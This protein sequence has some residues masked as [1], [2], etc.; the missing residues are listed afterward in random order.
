MERDSMQ[1]A[2]RGALILLLLTGVYGI[3]SFTGSY[4]RSID[5]S[6]IR[7]FNVSGEGEVIATPDIASFTFGVV[8][9]GG[10][11]TT[12]LQNQNTERANA[13]IAYLKENGIADEDIKTEFFDI[14]PRYQYF[15]CF[16][17]SG[18]A[19]PPA[20][21]VG[22]TI[23]QSVRV[24]V[25]EL[26]KAGELISGVVDAGANTVSQL[27]FMID[28]P[29]ALE[30]EAREKAFAEAR[31]KAEAL[32]EAGDFRVGKLL[33]VNEGFTGIPYASF[34]SF[35]DVAIGGK[36]GGIPSIESGSQTVRVNVNVRY[37]IR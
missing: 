9:E 6:S 34:E 28:D 24:K 23:N 22:Y 37:E 33:G 26:E 29:S 11:D 2:V 16:G 20:E 25:R 4:A 5:P 27:R 10:T 35:D 13:A 21:I 32:A 3:L 18:R 36:G 7:S 17:G 30:A 12:A 1:F 15:D 14:S 8:T 19:C 31:E